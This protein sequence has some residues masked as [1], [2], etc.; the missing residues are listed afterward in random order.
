MARFGDESEGL[1]SAFL[2]AG[3]AAVVSA[4]WAVSD[5]AALVMMLNLHAAMP[6]ASSLADALHT[7]QRRLRELT[8]DE[9]VNLGGRLTLALADRGARPVDGLEVGRACVGE[10]LRA[11][12][13]QAAAERLATTEFTLDDPEAIAAEL[14]R[15]CPREAV[16]GFRPFSHAAHWGA[17]TVHGGGRR[18]A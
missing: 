5:L 8:A 3:A 10:A 16:A 7:A 15:W 4:R 2:R 14:A 6:G 12:G 1:V 13:D 17:Y 11:A 9:L 18:V